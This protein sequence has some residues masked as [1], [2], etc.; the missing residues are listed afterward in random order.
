MKRLIAFATIGFYLFPVAHLSGLDRY[1][2][3]NASGSYVSRLTV[4][5]DE[6]TSGRHSRAL[7][8]QRK[9]ARLILAN[10]VQQ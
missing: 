10:T 8:I 3:T 7:R 4:N 6:G 5:A 1:A 9:L 2:A